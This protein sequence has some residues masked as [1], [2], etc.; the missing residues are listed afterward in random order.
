MLRL[1]IIPDL[2]FVSDLSAMGKR[3]KFIRWQHL[4]LNVRNLETIRN[5]LAAT[6]FKGKPH[7]LRHPLTVKTKDVFPSKMLI[8][9]KDVQIN[10]MYPW[11]PW[12][13]DLE[14]SWVITHL[15][16]G[17]RWHKNSPYS[18]AN[19]L[20]RTGTVW[21]DVYSIWTFNHREPSS[22]RLACKSGVK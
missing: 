11:L 1:I 21:S 3:C 4:H 14:R 9:L 13:A 2:C 17:S 8:G 12:C 7:L 20:S 19:M 18:A 22:S 5:Y 6:K 16:R 10:I 15:P